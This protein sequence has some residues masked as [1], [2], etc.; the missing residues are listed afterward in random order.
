MRRILAI[1]PAVV[2]AAGMTA[3]AWAS[4]GGDDHKVTLCHRTHS[5]TNPY[6]EITIDKAAVFKRGHDTHDE[7]GVHQPGDKAAGKWWGD[8]IP[9]F[10]YFASPQDEKTDTVSH[11]EGLNTDGL[12][13]LANHCE[14]VTVTSTPTPTE[15]VTPTETV[16]ASVTPTPTFTCTNLSMPTGGTC[17]NTTT[18]PPTDVTAPTT[19]SPEVTTS[20]VTPPENSR[21]IPREALPHTGL[22]PWV[23]A[24]AVVLLLLGG[25]AYWLARPR[26]AHRRT[27]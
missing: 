5:E 21:D 22:N 27:H 20:S 2:L 16:T 1:V 23:A 7:G 12:S 9:A 19:G 17:N 13:V 24:G 3:P 8:I 14:A 26:G 6:V 25:M 10:D 11:Y 4:Q 15:S 18:P